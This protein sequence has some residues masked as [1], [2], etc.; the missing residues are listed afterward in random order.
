MKYF[1]KE[2]YELC[3]KTSFHLPLEEEKQVE[4]FSEEY[5]QTLYNTELIRWLDFQEEVASITETTETG[6][7]ENDNENTS[8]NREQAIEQFHE[9]FLYNQAC[10]KK[11]L[12]EAI[13]KEIADIRVFALNKATRSV[14]NAVTNFCE[15][16]ER[17]IA[18]TSEKYRRYFKEASLSFDNEMVENF[19]FHDCTIIKSVQN[20]KSLTLLLDISGGFTNIDEVTFENCTIIKQDDLLDD[21]WWLY[22]EV[23][24]VNDQYE[25]HVLLQN[26]KMGL[27]DFII[28]A[29]QVSFK[30]N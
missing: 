21:S 7:R 15:N 16:N 5:F 20:G 18:A 26:S 1:T 28:S 14:I 22:E 19:G 13:V 8:F 29:D 12:P 10:L 6:N 11:E 25:F 23:Y 3:Q 24:Q 4:T 17:S 2:W 9:S 30:S 27:I